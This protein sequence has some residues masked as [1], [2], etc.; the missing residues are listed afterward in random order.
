MKSRLIYSS[1]LILHLIL[2]GKCQVNYRLPIEVVP[3][4]YALE[5]T[6]YFEAEN[7]FAAFSFS[8]N[9]KITLKT[10]VNSINKIVLHSNELSILPDFTIRQVES[11]D[12]YEI[13]LHEYDQRNHQNIFRLNR[14]LV[15]KKDYIFNINFIGNLSNDMHGFYKSSYDENGVTKHLAAT[16]FEPYHARRAFPCFDEPHFKA[17]FDLKLNRLSTMKPS[18]AN[19]RITSTNINGKRT[20]EI[21]K[22]TPIMSTYLLAFI[23]SDFEMRENEA[24][25]V[26]V[27]SR[28]TALSQTVYSLELAQKGL[29]LLSKT[30]EI[31]Y[32]ST[33][34]IEK[35]S[36]A[37]IP[38]FSAGAMEN[39]GLLT[40]RETALLY[41]PDHS[42]ITSQEKV[43]AT[44]IHEEVHMWFGDL[45]TCDWWSYSWLN[46]GFARYF[47]YFITAQIETAWK[48][49]WKFVTARL[50][51]VFG[52][53]SID[54]TK[55]MTVNAVQPNEI[56]DTFSTISYDKGA[57]VIRMVAH[58]ML[59]DKFMAGLRV[60]LKKQ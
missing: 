43:A 55:P 59:N 8:G 26:N 48:L 13:K 45:V 6:P 33:P 31:D 44:I 29:A 21:F 17:T 35:L 39:W 20:Q 16:Q 15:P 22:T 5:I 19:T 52:P 12:A 41:D 34:G 24:K 53:D 3:S 30:F 49:E 36:L 27:Y 51:S 40:Y 4:N 47:N 54:G 25:T 23:V 1:V 58:A 7:N 14:N 37:A 32:F 42:S 28:S 11:G 60:Y 50:Q 38:D 2:F 10:D 46:E 56:D 9:V 18:I 57:S